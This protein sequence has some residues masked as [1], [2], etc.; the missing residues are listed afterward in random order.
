[1]ARNPDDARF[2]DPVTSAP[3]DDP[4]VD[5]PI[6]KTPVQARQG[7]MG[8]PVLGVLTVGLALAVIAGMATGIVEF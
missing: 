6:V 5:D 1:M 4:I 3:I 7:F 2:F 8:W